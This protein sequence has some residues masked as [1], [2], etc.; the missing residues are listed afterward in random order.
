MVA[1]ELSVASA[2]AGTIGTSRAE[3]S[4]QVARS[5]GLW[6]SIAVGRARRG[7]TAA[8]SA[9]VAAWLALSGSVYGADSTTSPVPA[10][11]RT[12]D[13]KA[14]FSGIWESVSGAD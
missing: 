7:S 6:E 3:T 10:I 8:G 2:A 13:G 5:L 1:L 11:P 14:D 4:G 12:P 9:L